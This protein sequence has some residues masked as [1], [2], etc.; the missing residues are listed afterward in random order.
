M[1]L[2][3]HKKTFERITSIRNAEKELTDYFDLFESDPL[4]AEDADIQ[5]ELSELFKLFKDSV[6]AFEL[7]SFLSEPYD[8]NDA[9]VNLY[10]G[11]G[12]TDAQDW[13]EMLLRM[14][15][16]WFEKKRL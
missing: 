12:G 15:L 9:I 13:S 6:L 10:A 14:Y 16:R 1:Q 11:A 4:L 5:I 8:F 3:K 2:S 7:E